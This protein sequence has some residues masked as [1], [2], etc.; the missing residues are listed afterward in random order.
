MK[1][2]TYFI[3]NSA[4]L[5]PNILK[6]NQIIVN[7]SFN[8]KYLLHKL[9][10]I[11]KN[12]FYFILKTT[13]ARGAIRGGGKKP[14][15]QK[16][17]GC[18][19]QGS[20]RS[21]LYRGGGVIWGPKARR[22]KKKYNIKELKVTLQTIMY[23]YRFNLF[24]FDQLPTCS[25]KTKQIPW[26]FTLPNSLQSSLIISLNENKYLETNIKNLKNY[27]YL[28]VNK[29]NLNYLLKFKVLI[30]EESSFLFFIKSTY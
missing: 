6:K 23:N 17:T 29:V 1:L 2:F 21:P 15:K 25:F 3:L 12:N 13:K 7:T 16:G 27:S 5:K 10:S 22:N 26:L 19:R 18:A 8:S 20:L 30:F 14:F 24:I 4:T 28:P 11:T 9:I